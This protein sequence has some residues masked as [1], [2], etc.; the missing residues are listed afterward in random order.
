MT[1]IRADLVARFEDRR[2]IA[3]VVGLGYVGLPLAVETARSGY[4]TVG[5]DLSEPVVAGIN[6]RRSHIKDIPSKVLEP[7][8]AEGRL[9]ATTNASDLSDCDAISICVP[10]P[11]NKI[12]DP[13]LSYI[14]A[15]GKTVRDVLRRG[16]LVI[17]ES[18]TYPG[19]TREVLLPILEETGLKVGVDFFL[20]FSPERVDPGNPTWQTK[21]TP[22]VLGGVTP[23][24]AE[25]GLAFY[26]R[27]FDRMVPVESAEAAELVKVYENTFRMINIALANELAQ[28]CEKLDIDVWGVIDA[29]ATKPFGFM[30]FTPGPGLGGHCIPLDPHYLAWKMRTLSY[31]TRMIEVASEIN[32][33]MP[34]YVVNQVADVLNDNGVALSRA[35]VLVLGIA[36]KKD[37]DDL[38]ESPALDIIQKLQQKGAAVSYHDPFCPQIADDGHTS[39]KGLPMFSV[40]FSAQA[41]AEADVVLIVTDHSSVDYQSV[42]DNARA[43]VDTRGV[44]RKYSGK[45]KVLGLSGSHR[46]PQ[47]VAG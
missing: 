42:C 43:V 45:A 31:T 18:T 7:L 30:K 14:V 17:L 25:V 5:F 33:E 20:C 21:N 11:L 40:P 36:Y 35:K 9:K 4:T 39:I 2:A 37:I 6:A 44:T 12:K 3:G 24:C 47:P 13:D 38:R 8:V 15:A 10:T 46:V 32:T 28:A 22:K 19:T 27:V 26:S 23:E 16:H 29:A 34:D 41:V 1:T